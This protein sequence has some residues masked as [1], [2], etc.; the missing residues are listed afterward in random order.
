M[1]DGAS[2]VSDFKLNIDGPKATSELKGTFSFQP[3]DGNR[4]E[5]PVDVSGSIEEY[6][7]FMKP[8][9]SDRL[10][11]MDL[12][13]GA[14]LTCLTKDCTES[15]VDIY[16][17]HK[18]VIYHH[19][20]EAKGAQPTTQQ[21]A[22]P[23]KESPAKDTFSANSKVKEQKVG[24]QKVADPK[25]KD[26]KATEPTKVP[27]EEATEEATDKADDGSQYEHDIDEEAEAGTYVGEPQRDIEVLFPDLDANTGKADAGKDQESKKDEK[28]DDKNIP[29]SKDINIQAKPPKTLPAQGSSAS[30]L[31]NVMVKGLGQAVTA[32]GTRN[33]VKGHLE[34]P[35]DIFNYE[36]SNPQVGFHI[37]Y[38]KRKAYF[39]T[40]DMLA[41][42]SNMGRYSRN[43]VNGYVLNVGDISAKNGGPLG[44]HSSHQMGLDADISY[45]FD[46]KEKQ[47]G[48]VDAV[49]S[50]RP[51]RS[52]MAEEQWEMFKTFVGQGNVDRIF[53]HPALKKELCGVAAKKGDLNSSNGTAFETLRVMRPEVHHDN[54]F[55]L[56]LKCSTAQPRCRQMAPPA[57]GTGC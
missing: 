36:E 29:P 14:K 6:N 53:I 40:D 52:F 3:A 10:K 1:V 56:R 32:L 39:G 51:L 25:P 49:K 4:I 18:G 2:Q 17:V 33:L 46:A 34:N 57:K 43:K 27:S 19:Q 8:T 12:Q 35:T 42:L 28:K 24:D 45:Y 50:S 37:L 22:T 41:M 15:F 31:I 11:V 55:H 13:S 38:P 20:V 9:N 48:L 23:V 54:H 44:K 7:S 47:K 5:V 21:P 16:V 26:Q 30:R